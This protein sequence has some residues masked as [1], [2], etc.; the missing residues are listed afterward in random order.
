[1]KKFLARSAALALGASM[2]FSSVTAFATGVDEVEELVI[3]VE[4]TAFQEEVW[5]FEEG[6]ISEESEEVVEILGFSE[7]LSVEFNTNE[8]LN[9]ENSVGIDALVAVD[10]ELIGADGEQAPLARANSHNS[11][12]TA[13]SLPNLHIQNSVSS[14]PQG[15]WYSWIVANDLSG[16]NAPDNLYTIIFNAPVNYQL[17]LTNRDLTQIWQIPNNVAIHLTFADLAS[18]FGFNHLAITN[19]NLLLT[20]QITQGPIWQPYSLFYGA[21]HRRATTNMINTGLTF[22][23][24]TQ[25]VP[26]PLFFN[27]AELIFT[28]MRNNS[29]VPDAALITQMWLTS[30]ATGTATS[31]FEKFLRSL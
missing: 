16:L 25:N 31:G 21:T 17:L 1:M 24:G 22:N 12:A 10:I 7:A 28:G 9:D 3:P 18:M 29:S 5:D 14:L 2:I 6:F 11:I 15:T 23:F 4:I 20:V 26:L 13:L 27:S 8:V 19:L 30:T